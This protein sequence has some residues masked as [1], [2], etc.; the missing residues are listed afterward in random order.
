MAR[1]D[2]IQNAC[3]SLA[4]AK[5]LHKHF[6]FITAVLVYVI[7]VM[8]QIRYNP[9]LGIYFWYKKSELLKMNN[10]S[11]QLN[12]PVCVEK[13]ILS[14]VSV[15]Q[16]RIMRNVP[17]TALTHY[18]LPEYRCCHKII[19][20]LFITYLKCAIVMCVTWTMIERFQFINET[21]Y[22]DVDR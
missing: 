21:Y 5:N 11:R 4:L 13:Q 15:E 7:L 20:I 22:I 17:V 10:V 9:I 14:L 2:A 1:D 19:T 3:G 18:L 8:V 16:I 6:G 12:E